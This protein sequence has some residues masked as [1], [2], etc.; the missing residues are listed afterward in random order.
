M[1]DV[2]VKELP[3]NLINKIV[4]IYIED[5]TERGFIWIK[6]C[7]GLLIHILIEDG[8]G[9]ISTTKAKCKQEYK[10]NE[11]YIFKVNNKK[12]Y[13]GTDEDINCEVSTIWNNNKKH[14]SNPL[15]SLRMKYIPKGKYTGEK[16]W[17]K[18]LD[19]LEEKARI[20]KNEKEITHYL[21]KNDEVLVYFRDKVFVFGVNY[22]ILASKEGNQTTELF[23][24]V[25]HKDSIASSLNKCKM[26]YQMPNWVIKL[27]K[28]YDL[29]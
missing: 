18:R 9:N 17:I 28:Q 19:K 23:E 14:S 20:L 22:C 21:R 16:N 7:N 5:I 10:I 24:L 11:P 4:N 27:I 29:R 26:E 12:I 13:V 3:K 2:Q 25:A 6:K 1:Y 8:Y 15:E